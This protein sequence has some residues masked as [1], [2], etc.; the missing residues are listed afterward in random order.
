M[1]SIA[2]VIH[3]KS[4]ALGVVVLTVRKRRVCGEVA[5]SVRHICGTTTVLGIKENKACGNTSLAHMP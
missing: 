2:L 4:T 3:M 5:M 1:L